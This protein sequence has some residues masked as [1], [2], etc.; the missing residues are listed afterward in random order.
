MNK[1]T[2]IQRLCIALMAGLG[3]LTLMPLAYGASEDAA[4]QLW[5]YRD[6]NPGQLKVAV[7]QQQLLTGETVSPVV[8]PADAPV[9]L[10]VF[11]DYQCM[12][13]GRLQNEISEVT[14]NNPQ[15][16]V[17]FKDWPIFASRW[18]ASLAAAKT[19]LQIW[20]QKGNDAYIQYH[21]AVFS[22]G[23]TEGTLTDND[24]RVAAQ[25]TGFAGQIAPVVDKELE[26]VN[27]LALKLG[28]G[29]TP[30]MVV[31]P[32]GGNAKADQVTVIPGFVPADIIRAAI[33][34]AQE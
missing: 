8:G 1:V 16:R 2:G 34:K 27:S 28:F 21:Q 15:L 29:G 11:F 7:E 12:Y 22:S 18:P 26:S 24:I 32:S 20:R 13:C 19:G 25:A 5:E 14:R 4:A 33:K 9:T 17:V 31:M 10:V 6:N 3:C 23:K 30:A